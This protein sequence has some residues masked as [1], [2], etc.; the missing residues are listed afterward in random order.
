MHLEEIQPWAAQILKDHPELAGVPVL[1]DDG[2]YPK[3]PQREEALNTKGLVLVVWQ[4]ESEGLQDSATNGS[5]IEDLSMAVVIEENAAVSRRQGGLGISA[6]KALR[7]VRQALVG[8]YIEPNSNRRLLPGDPPFKNFGTE[9]GV[10]RI[11][12]MLTM[13]LPIER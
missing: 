13:E 12:A 5:C 11:V 10:Q 6:M 7:L 3:T 4:L 2:S 8:K 9:N 1:L